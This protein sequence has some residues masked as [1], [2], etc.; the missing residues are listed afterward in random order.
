MIALHSKTI[1]VQQQPLT[2]KWREWVAR[3]LTVKEAQ[4]ADKWRTCAIGEALSLGI[5]FEMDD[6]ADLDQAVY[7]LA[8]PLHDLA[9]HFTQN[10]E[11]PRV[12]PIIMDKIDQAIW[13]HGGPLRLMTRI[14]DRLDVYAQRR[15]ARERA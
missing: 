15:R 1:T 3:G 8:K 2:P 4:M 12:A 13:A 5:E 6:E 14:A 7:E 11:N 10:A 9:Y